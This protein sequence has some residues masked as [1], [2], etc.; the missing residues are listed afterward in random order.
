MEK[1]F[2]TDKMGRCES[3]VDF[4][5]LLVTISYMLQKSINI[6]KANGIMTNTLAFFLFFSTKV[7]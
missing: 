6:N 2:F 7:S 3:Y 1:Y 5:A 4:I